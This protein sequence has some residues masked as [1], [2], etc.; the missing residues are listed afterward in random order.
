MI[1]A[2][3]LTLALTGLAAA[4]NAQTPPSLAATVA[5]MPKGIARAKGPALDSAIAAARAAVAACAADGHKVSALIVDSAGQPVVLL[6]GDGAGYR[7]QLIARTKANTVVKYR[8]RSLEVAEKAA[9]DP[10]LAAEIAADPDIGMAR[11]GGVPIVVNGEFLGAF[12]VSGA[13]GPDEDCVNAAL[14]KAPLH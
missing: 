2:A 5:A 1:R 11:G 4:A 9:K 13:F 6:S 14:A 3:V 10:K 7:S 8:L 12:A